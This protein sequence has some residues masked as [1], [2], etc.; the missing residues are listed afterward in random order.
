MEHRTLPAESSEISLLR[1][2][3]REKKYRT[4]AE[5]FGW[6]FVFEDFVSD[7]LRNRATQQMKVR[8]PG[9]AV[10]GTGVGPGH[11]ILWDTESPGPQQTPDLRARDRADTGEALP[12]RAGGTH[13]PRK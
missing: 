7:E 2:F 13:T 3:V 12:G 8:K 6:S 10:E 9:L 1:E 4:E 5:T 11:R